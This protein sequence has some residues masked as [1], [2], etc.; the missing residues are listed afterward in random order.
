VGVEAGG[1]DNYLMKT[2]SNLL[3]M[4]GM[5]LRVLVRSRLH[6]EAHIA[7]EVAEVQRAKEK[8]ERRV[9]F[10]QKQVETGK[11][12]QERKLAKRR[13][14]QAASRMTQNLEEGILG[15]PPR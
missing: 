7:E 4:E 5:R 14:K 15:S 1:L 3:G 13:E 12:R 9:A 8:E 10:Q 2:K 6:E 11:E